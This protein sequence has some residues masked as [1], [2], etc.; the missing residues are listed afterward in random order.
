MN[1]T[2]LYHKDETSA[3]IWYCGQC[4]IV[5]KEMAQA[6]QCCRPYTCRTC[7][8][9]APKYYTICMECQTS[10]MLIKEAE[11]FEKAEKLTEW[12]GPVQTD[13]VGWN[14]GFFASLDD[15]LEYLADW[16]DNH[17]EP[18]PTYAW[19]CDSRPTCALDVGRIIDDATQEAHEDFNTDSL[20]GVEELRAA[21]DR[22]NEANKGITTWTPN[23]K[24]V[25]LLTPTPATP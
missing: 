20:K 22:F 2:E 16:E 19:A 17:E 25:V 9:E 8:K 14:D 15:L 5:H 1:A 12:D 10:A 6:E 4:R 3:G 24:K 7:G 23:Y 21:I 18:K 13:A 11:R